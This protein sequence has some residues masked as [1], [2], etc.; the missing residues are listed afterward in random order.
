[1]TNKMLAGI[2]FAIAAVGGVAG[3]YGYLNL[4]RMLTQP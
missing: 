2:I 3:V 1:M 4:V